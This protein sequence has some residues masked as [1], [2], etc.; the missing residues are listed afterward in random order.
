MKYIGS[1]FLKDSSLIQVGINAKNRLICDF[2]AI[3][4]T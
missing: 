4:Q 2:L 1:I 3:H